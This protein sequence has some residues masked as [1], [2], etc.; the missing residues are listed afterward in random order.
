[1]DTSIQN[2]LT[3]DYN[4]HASSA[5]KYEPHRGHHILVIGK[6]GTL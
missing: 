1:M 5:N 2:S 3:G 4:D 6:S